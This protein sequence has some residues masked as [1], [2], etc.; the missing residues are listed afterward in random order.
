MDKM[1]HWEQFV[2]NLSGVMN[3]SLISKVSSEESE[4]AATHFINSPQASDA[5]R[6]RGCGVQNPATVGRMFHCRP[7]DCRSSL[8]QIVIPYFNERSTFSQLADCG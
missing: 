3:K 7:R 2:Y 4:A 8:N 1:L 6:H 5:Y